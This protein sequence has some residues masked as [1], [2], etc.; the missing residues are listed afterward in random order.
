MHRT[1]KSS[2]RGASLVI[3]LER[4]F[5]SLSSQITTQGWISPVKTLLWLN[6]RIRH[7]IVKSC[8]SE[9]SQVLG[10]FLY[11]LENHYLR[12]Y[13]GCEF[14]QVMMLRSVKSCVW[15]GFSRVSA[16]LDI[17]FMF[18]VN[19]YKKLR[20]A[21]KPGNGSHGQSSKRPSSDYFR[22]LKCLT[23]WKNV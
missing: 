6:S 8:T 18:H 12:L 9:A 10:C 7:H 17:S 5:P 22:L 20:F 15:E 16:H 19:H 11:L 13:F 4:M 2:K 3:Q 1:V 23:Q 21:L 14:S